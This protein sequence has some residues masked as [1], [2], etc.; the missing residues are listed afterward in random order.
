MPAGM[1]SK[2][3]SAQPYWLLK[4]RNPE[5]SKRDHFRPDPFPFDRPL[6]PW[7]Y[8]QQPILIVMTVFVYPTQPGSATSWS[9]HLGPTD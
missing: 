6:T 5:S 7:A 9:G 2:E 8:H 4:V 1:P 3:G